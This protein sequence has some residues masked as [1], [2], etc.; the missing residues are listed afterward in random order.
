[1]AGGAFFGKVGVIGGVR[2]WDA[3]GGKAGMLGGFHDR[4][5]WGGLFD[6]PGGSVFRIRIV[7]NACEYGSI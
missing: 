6:L 1:M 4:D 7:W 5:A 3:R 2:D